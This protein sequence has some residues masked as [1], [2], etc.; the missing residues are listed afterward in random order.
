[1]T[2]FVLNTGRTPRTLNLI[3][4]LVWTKKLAADSTENRGAVLRDHGSQVEKR[5]YEKFPQECLF[6]LTCLLLSITD[7]NDFT[8]FVDLSK[9]QMRWTRNP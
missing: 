2:L 9:P 8:I 7:F 3:D 5:E 1:V 6:L 4:N